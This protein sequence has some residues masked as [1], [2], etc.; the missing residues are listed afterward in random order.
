M[1]QGT[2]RVPQGVSLAPRQYL[3]Q[4][5]ALIAAM[6]TPPT[7]ARARLMDNL[8]LAL[9]TAG[10]FQNMDLLYVTCAADSQAARLNWINPGTNTLTPINGPIFTADVGYAGDGVAAYL[11]TG[12]ANNGAGNKYIASNNCHG[13][14]ITATGTG[15]LD[16]GLVGS[17]SMFLNCNNAGNSE[18][19]TQMNSTGLISAGGGGIGTYHAQRTASNASALYRNGASVA[20]SAI[21]SVA[22]GSQNF[23]FLRVSATTSSDRISE[24]HIGL[25]LAVTSIPIFYNALKTYINSINPGLVP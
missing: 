10:I 3:P 16:V 11:N 19:R 25:S 14:I 23:S 1:Q 13:A 18:S 4:T 17:S 20:T 9:I 15:A 24:G 22:L 8:M 21:T 6:T 12:L 2:L 5:N 7:A